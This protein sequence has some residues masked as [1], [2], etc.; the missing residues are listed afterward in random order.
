MGNLYGF[1]G[2]LQLT[3]KKLKETAYYSSRHDPGA[4]KRHRAVVA[5]GAEKP[6]DLTVRSDTGRLIDLAGPR[7]FVGRFM[8]L[9]LHVER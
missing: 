5:G 8:F 2:R 6:S 4:K 3:S 7:S 9:A 1:G